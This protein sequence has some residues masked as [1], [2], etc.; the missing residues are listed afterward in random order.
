MAHQI[1]MLMPFFVKETLLQNLHIVPY[2]DFT[3]DDPCN[4]ALRKS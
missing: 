1:Q 3:L 4:L 2:P